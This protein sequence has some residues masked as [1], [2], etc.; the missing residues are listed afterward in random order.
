FCGH[1]GTGFSDK[2]LTELHKKM[3]PLITQKSPFAEVPKT[4][5]T[6]TWLKPELIAEIKFTETTEEHIFRH[7]VFLRLRE[8]LRPEDLDT[9][10]PQEKLKTESE[11]PDSVPIKN[12]PKKTAEELT[13]FGDEKVRLTNQ[14]KIYFPKDGISKGDLIAYYQRMAEYILRSEEHTSELQS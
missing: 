8:D 14:N 3:E 9:A 2:T 13:N 4:N 10:K 6:A 11:L 1:T 7:P 12:T 5:D